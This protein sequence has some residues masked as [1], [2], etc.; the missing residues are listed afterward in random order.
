MQSLFLS[1]DDGPQFGERW[2]NSGSR[3]C[4]WKYRQESQGRMGSQ[5]QRVWVYALFNL[6]SRPA[7]FI[8]RP[9][10][11]KAAPLEAD[12]RTDKHLWLIRATEFRSALTRR[13]ALLTRAATRTSLGD[14][15]LSDI[16]HIHKGQIVLMWLHVR[17]VPRV[18][19]E[20]RLKVTRDWGK[21]EN[22]EF[23]FIQ[24]AQSF[25]LEWLKSSGNRWWWWVAQYVNILGA[26]GLCT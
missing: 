25:C 16:S 23:V 19:T 5:W 21:E 24:W 14:I 11:Q 22:R 15:V 20:S 13:D 17:E 3:F 4:K 10:S 2:A 26:T 9:H 7:K 12:A 8:N 6:H 18:E 1:V